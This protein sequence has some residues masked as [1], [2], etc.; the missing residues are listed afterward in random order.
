MRQRRRIMLIVTASV[1]LT[2]MPLT[3]GAD[4]T[5]DEPP[6][7]PTEERTH[8]FCYTYGGPPRVRVCVPPW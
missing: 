7:T 5:E 6:Q 2:A 3:V 1:A 4:T 8:L